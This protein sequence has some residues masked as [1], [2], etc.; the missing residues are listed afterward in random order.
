MALISVPHGLGLFLDLCIT[1]QTYLAVAGTPFS[2]LVRVS[3]LWV[4][5][6]L[7]EDRPTPKVLNGRIL[8]NRSVLKKRGYFCKSYNVSDASLVRGTKH[9]HFLSFVIFYL[10]TIF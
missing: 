7:T 4:G 10:L 6:A 8:G 1:F 9:C 5:V 3:Y 2:L